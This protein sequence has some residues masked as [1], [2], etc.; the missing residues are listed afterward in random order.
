MFPKTKTKKKSKEPTAKQRRMFAK[1]VAVGCMACRKEHGIYVPAEIH[2]VKKYGYRNHNDVIGLCPIH[3]RPT[4]GVTGIPNYH[5]NKIEFEAKF[6]TDRQLM[7]ECRG[8]IQG[9]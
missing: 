3:H 2:H 9:E 1:V 4:F 8:I 7:I 5:G 6:G